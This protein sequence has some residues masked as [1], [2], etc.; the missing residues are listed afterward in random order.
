VGSGRE[1]GEAGRDRSYRSCPG[2]GSAE[3]DHS[4]PAFRRTAVRT[5]YAAGVGAGV[6]CCRLEQRPARRI[7]EASSWVIWPWRRPGLA[8]PSKSSWYFPQAESIDLTR[9]NPSWP[10][11][12]HG[13][14]GCYVPSQF[15][16]FHGRQAAD[17]ME[18]VRGK[19]EEARDYRQSAGG[20]R[21]AFLGERQVPRRGCYCPI[22]G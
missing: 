8:R 17:T 9:G 4:A 18:S 1:V 21:G 3:S 5:Q 19:A 2:C 13:A 16:R 12:G 11:H 7:A 6:R 22:A 10:S 14:E 20:D 15:P